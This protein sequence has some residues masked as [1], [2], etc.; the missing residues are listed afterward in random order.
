M[1]S[2]LVLMLIAGLAPDPSQNEGSP[3]ESIETPVPQRATLERAT[4]WPWAPAPNGSLTLVRNAGQW[5]EE[6]RFVGRLPGMLVRVERAGLALQLE[7]NGGG[8]GT[9]VRL[10][11]E[12]ASADADPQGEVQSEGTYSFFIGN[13]PSRWRGGVRGYSKVRREELYPGIAWVVRGEGG[14]LE[15]DLLV[16]PG[17]ELERVVLRCEGLE[18]LQVDD[19]AASLET[20]LGRLLHVPGRSWQVLPSGETREVECTWKANGDDRLVP[21]V[22]ERDPNL[23]LV[24]DPGLVWSTYLGGSNST[25]DSAVAVA[26][27]RAGNVFVT[28]GTASID[29]PQSAGAFLLPKGQYNVFITKLRA[30][31]GALVYSSVFGGSVFNQQVKDIAVDA[32]GHA[33]VVGRTEASDF[34]TTSQAWQPSKQSPAPYWAGFATQLT[35]TGDA[36]AFS[37]YVEG[38]QSGGYLTAVAMDPQSRPILAGS[39]TG[40]DFPTTPGA[41]QTTWKGNDCCI[42]RLD[43]SGGT[44]EWSTYLGGSLPD[45]PSFKGLA[46][47]PGSGD[48]LLVGNAASSDFPTTPGAYATTKHPSLAQS[49]FVTRIESS[50]SNLVWS[51]YLGGTSSN[52]NDA[53]WDIAIDATGSVTV[54]GVTNSKTFPTT[55]GA[56]LTQFVANTAH[57]FVTRFD[58]TGKSLIYSTYIG[59]PSSSGGIGG[60]AVDPSG[61]ATVVGGNSGGQFPITPGAFMTTSNSPD[62]YVARLSPAGDRLFYSS[63]IGG[64]S[65]EVPTAL[66]MSI[67]RR[68]TLT[69][70]CYSPGGYP[71]TPNAFQPNYGGGQTDAVVTSLDLDL[72]GNAPFGTSTPACLGPIA[73][74]ATEMPAAGAASYSLYCSAAPPL[75][76]GWLILG[77]RAQA[78]TTV[79]GVSIWIDLSLPVRK[80]PIAADAAGYVET[81]F[82]LSSAPSGLKFAGQYLFRNTSACPGSGPWSASNALDV[83]VQ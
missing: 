79:H 27:D 50:G 55:P 42:L 66:A 1:V 16:A 36:L 39:A 80:L 20:K 32:R 24:I 44:L 52:E 22:P 15:Y 65:T 82:P 34:P 67:A 33:S 77:R 38:P 25:G 21:H 78:A 61:I 6:A 18:D 83:M 60:L 5:P 76:K 37:T 17:A 9:L 41:F 71:T 43:A 23:P 3:F 81:Q 10:T 51:T 14:G 2:F 64:L 68:A 28:G 40:P 35:A 48:V 7:R 30:G 11:F 46:V 31:D 54:A 56:F 59:G 19:D 8:E 29:F 12:G 58:V 49:L 69:G 73:I 4:S 47:E 26:L 57:G 13:D 72:Q 74:N 62:A 53:A 63:F 70:Y 75:A 45:G